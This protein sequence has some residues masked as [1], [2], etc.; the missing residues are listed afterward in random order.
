MTDRILVGALVG[1]EF[2]TVT[3]DGFVDSA[4]V[5][6]ENLLMKADHFA[7]EKVARIQTPF[8]RGQSVLL[9]C[10][11]AFTVIRACLLHLNGAR[12]LARRHF[13]TDGGKGKM[14]RRVND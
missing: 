12:L 14:M 5:T 11:W 6:P 7:E 8:C 3:V 1:E 4:L 2:S 10:F 9:R 13:P